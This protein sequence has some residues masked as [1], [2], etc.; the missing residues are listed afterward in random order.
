MFFANGFVR[1]RRAQAQSAYAACVCGYMCM[2]FLFY[3]A[4]FIGD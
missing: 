3:D 2:F 4:A 1:E